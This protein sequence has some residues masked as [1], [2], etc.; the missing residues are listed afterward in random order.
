LEQSRICGQGFGERNYHIF[1]QLCAGLPTDTWHSLGLQTPDHFHYLNQG[2][3]QFLGSKKNDSL[4]PSE[5]KSGEHRSQ[6]I[7]VDAI[8]DDLADFKAM[9]AALTNF[10]VSAEDKNYIYQIVAAVLH[11]GNI[12]FEDSPDDKKGGCRLKEGLST[13]SSRLASRLIGVDANELNQCLLTRIMQTKQ[14]GRQGTA[15]LVPLKVREAQNARDALAKAI[16][17]KLFDHLVT[18]IVNKSIPFSQSAYYIGVLDIAGFEYFRMNSFEQFCINYCNEKLQQFFNERILKEE[19]SIYS[20]EGLGLR[21]IEFVDNQDCID[22][23]EMKASGIFDLLDEESKLPKPSANHFTEAVH[24][25]HAGHFRIDV[26]RKSKLKDHREIRDDEGFLIRHFAGAVCYHTIAFI[27]KNS[28]ALHSSLEC[29]MSDAKNPLVAS[30]FLQSKQQQQSANQN[31]HL[32][33]NFTGPPGGGGSNKAGKLA[34]TSVGSRFRSQLSDLMM[35]LRSTGTHFIRCIK[36]NLDLVAGK[37]E[38]SH[39]LSQL[40]CSGMGS[41][42]ELMQQGYPS[43]TSF[44]DLYNMYKSLLPPDLARLDPRTFCRAL[45]KA[46]GLNEA[47]FKFGSTRIFFRPG[48]FAEFDQIMQSDPQHLAQLISKVQT[49]LL[50]SRWKKIQW[51][52]LCVI[53]RK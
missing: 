46:L 18:K 12:S 52:A 2:C 39:I 22:L 7:L 23:L 9:D 26:P 3:T 4:I 42:L 41:V 32:S 24:A 30:L 53:R 35:K 1:Y 6:G 21:Q 33:V 27:D 36:P 11:L 17:S 16:Y 34:Y 5:R 40:R 29:L 8:V 51:A 25:A 19:Q 38:G 13:E 14:G 44:T 45:F 47:D 43:R 10:G 49:W 50:I 15:Y 37:F 31:S 28:D 48:K 20:K